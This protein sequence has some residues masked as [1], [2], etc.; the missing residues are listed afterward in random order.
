MDLDCDARLHWKGS[1]R[2]AAANDISVE[3][4]HI[5]RDPL[6]EF[7]RCE[8]HVAHGIVLSH[9]AANGRNDLK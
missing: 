8:E 2:S 5:A 3:Q 4:C 1:T 7:E 9:P 6:Y